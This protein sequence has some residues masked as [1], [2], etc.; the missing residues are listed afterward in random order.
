MS[1][2]HDKA[3]I[4]PDSDA[5][6]ALK[7]ANLSGL[8]DT[9][10]VMAYAV[11]NDAEDTFFECLFEEPEEFHDAVEKFRTFHLN[12]VHQQGRRGEL[13]PQLC[14]LPLDAVDE[15]LNNM[16]DSQIMDK[17]FHFNTLVHVVQ[18]VEQVQKLEELQQ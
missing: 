3:W 14:Y 12:L 8:F 10:V 17:G 13:P 5:K 9:L 4:K 16:S 11:E 6:D 2:N 18:T 1:R 15:F 7:D